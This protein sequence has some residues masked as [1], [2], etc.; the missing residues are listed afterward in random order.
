[1]LITAQALCQMPTYIC[2]WVHLPQ[3]PQAC[4]SFDYSLSALPHQLVLSAD[5]F[6]GLHTRAPSPPAEAPSMPHSSTAKL[7]ARAAP[8][9]LPFPPTPTSTGPCPCH[10]KLSL[11]VSP[12]ASTWPNPTPTSLYS[13]PHRRAP[14]PTTAALWKHLLPRFQRCHRL[15]KRDLAQ[16]PGFHCY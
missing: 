11:T 9:H 8:P 14:Q 6:L 12:P 2:A 13:A 1:M 5:L 7:L 16:A 3:L 15:S 10:S 4:R